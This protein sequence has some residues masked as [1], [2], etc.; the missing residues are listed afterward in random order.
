MKRFLINLLLSV[1]PVAVFALWLDWRVVKDLRHSNHGDYGVWNDLYSGRANKDLLI[2]GSSRAWV[3]IDPVVL[4]DSVRMSV[5]N[6]G[7]DGYNFDMSSLRHDIIMRGVPPKVIVYALDGSTL[8]K[9]KDLYNQAQ[10]L[11]YLDDDALEKRISGYEGYS[12]WDARLPFVKFIGQY[13]VLFRWFNG[14]FSAGVP[15]DRYR[16][17]KAQ[18]VNWTK[19]VDE[20][21]KHQKQLTQPLDTSSIRRFELFLQQCRASHIRVILTY[22]PEH[23]LGQQFV[24]NRTS[25]IRIYRSLASIYDIPFLDYSSD[26]LCMDKKYFYNS[27]HLNDVGA[28]IYSRKLASALKGILKDAPQ[29]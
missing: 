26:T 12:A 29:K 19:D 10:F 22:P 27:Q 9:R 4:E 13:R 6:L 24:S 8:F 18:H 15:A 23:I 7:V 14:D 2:Y 20:L 11:P 3:H 1:L 17:F 21:I 16:G 5:Y 28:T 25:I